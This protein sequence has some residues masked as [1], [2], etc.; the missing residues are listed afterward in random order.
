[1]DYTY[2]LYR[3]KI[4]MAEEGFKDLA[5]ERINKAMEHIKNHDWYWAIFYLAWAVENLVSAY[6]LG[7]FED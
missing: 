6:V 4:A 7:E 5:I 2:N 1:M 3:G